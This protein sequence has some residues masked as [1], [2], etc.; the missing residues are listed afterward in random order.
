MLKIDQVIGNTFTGSQIYTDGRWHPVS[1]ELGTDG[2]LRL[3]GSG[4]SWDMNRIMGGA[5]SSSYTNVGNSSENYLRIVEPKNLPAEKLEVSVHQA[6]LELSRVLGREIK[7]LSSNIIS[8]SKEE[9]CYFGIITG[10]MEKVMPAAAVGPLNDLAVDITMLG[11]GSLGT[12]T[13]ANN[14]ARDF[15]LDIGSAYFKSERIDIAMARSIT[16]RSIG[17]IIPAI[18]AIDPD[19]PPEVLAGLTTDLALRSVREIVESEG[20]IHAEF[21]GNNAES[22]Y[23]PSLAPLADMEAKWFYSPS[24]HYLSAFLSGECDNGE[25]GF[26]LVRFQLEKGIALGVRVV[27][28]SLEIFDKYDFMGS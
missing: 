12:G 28:G 3:K 17:Y 1:G 22:K 25:S 21:S 9:Q 16:E 2:V 7:R 26:Y 15:V 23:Y 8:Q 4:F 19:H 10:A 20:V 14:L 6:N 13:T 18:A 11:L 27:E 24:S 5:E